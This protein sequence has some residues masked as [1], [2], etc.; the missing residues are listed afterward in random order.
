[1]TLCL[2]TDRSNFSSFLLHQ[3]DEFVKWVPEDSLDIYEMSAIK[4]NRR[5][6]EYLQVNDDEYSGSFDKYRMCVVVFF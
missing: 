2:L 6:A 5:R 1:M 4:D 3:V